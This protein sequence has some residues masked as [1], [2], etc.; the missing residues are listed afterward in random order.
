[1]PD[2][3]GPASDM[4]RRLMLAKDAP[5]PPEGWIARKLKAHAERDELNRMVSQ[6][7]TPKPSLHDLDVDWRFAHADAML[8]FADRDAEVPVEP[9]P[10]PP[11][12]PDSDPPITP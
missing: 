12:D 4:T 10:D 7:R 11:V 5:P 1:M 9:T 2:T 8:A 6:P 3:S